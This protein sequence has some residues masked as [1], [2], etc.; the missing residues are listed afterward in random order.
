MPA[1]F[2]FPIVSL[3]QALPLRAILLLFLLLL[4]CVLPPLWFGLTLLVALPLFGLGVRFVPGQLCALLILLSV[5]RSSDAD[6]TKENRRADDS[7]S[8]HEC[9]LTFQLKR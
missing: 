2:G 5:G 7:K 3:C 8:F 4:P 6:K 9:R 1:S